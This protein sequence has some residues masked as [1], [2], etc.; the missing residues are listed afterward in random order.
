MDKGAA[1]N[2]RRSKPEVGHSAGAP[3]TVCSRDTVGKKS[4]YAERKVN[5]FDTVGKTMVINGDGDSGVG[6]SPAAATATGGARQRNHNRH[7]RGG[8]WW[9]DE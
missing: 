5:T 3:S 8:D 6:G 1:L 2:S 7:S 9:G 4:G